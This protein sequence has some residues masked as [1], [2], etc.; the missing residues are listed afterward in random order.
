M[1]PRRFERPTLAFGAQAEP[2]QVVRGVIIVLDDDPEYG[3]HLRFRRTLIFFGT[4]LAISLLAHAD[5]VETLCSYR[6][7]KGICAVR[8]AGR[9]KRAAKAGIP[10]RV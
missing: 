4:K 2:A 10:R 1:R 7:A 3:G 6:H 9:I 8:T 5:R